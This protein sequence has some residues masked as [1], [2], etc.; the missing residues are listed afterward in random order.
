MLQL[1][2]TLQSLTANMTALSHSFQ[3]I[4]LTIDEEEAEPDQALKV[5]IS[6]YVTVL[7]GS[8]GITDGDST[9]GNVIVSAT[10][11][12]GEIASGG[13]DAG[14]VGLML[15]YEDRDSRGNIL[16]WLGH[17]KSF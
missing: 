3:Q 12:L 15:K 9:G 5:C 4:V 7:A 14:S 8:S 6:G 1:S 13:E 10:R 2:S 16:V 17:G 11:G